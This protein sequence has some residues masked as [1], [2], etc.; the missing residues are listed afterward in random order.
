[1]DVGHAA[2][3]WLC[4]LPA[5]AHRFRVT[6][7]RLASALGAAGAELVEDS[8][9][10]EVGS[11]GALRGDAALAVVSLGSPGW[12]RGTLAARIAKRARSSV[13]V[14]I[15]AA[16]AGRKLH[17]LGYPLSEM[18]TWDL[19]HVFRVPGGINGELFARS[20]VEHLPQCALVFGY[21]EA[22]GESLVEAA[23]RDAGTAIGSRLKANRLFARGGLTLAFTDH[24]LVRVSVGPGFSQIE[25]Q[26]AALEALRSEGVPDT[27]AKRVPWQGAQGKSNLADWAVEPLLPGSSA[28]APLSRNLMMECLDFL[29]ALH[30]VK[31]SGR[32]DTSLTAAAAVVA[33][34][35]GPAEAAIVHATGRA[36]DDALSDVPRGFG[37]GDY[38][39][40]NLLV[41]DDR[42]VGVV[43]WDSAGPDRLALLDAIHLAFTSGHRPTDTD[44]GPKLV[45]ELI[46]WARAGGDDLTNEY[47]REVGLERDPEL[48]ELLVVAYWLD[49]AA[50]QLRTHAERWE[51]GDWVR[52][53]IESVARALG[54]KTS[55]RGSPLLRLGSS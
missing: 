20:P 19:G 7:A 42:L 8:P 11:P 16:Q 10:V 29:T 43:D 46:P 47:C 34:V 2:Q 40:G 22:L 33:R 48:L 49:R 12:V 50:S 27:V 17:R 6:D 5:A 32:W 39:M 51:D 41:V 13:R 21:R 14:R 36:L 24:G 23:V 15:Q 38:S 25:A 26:G 28:R 37:H 44:W 55:R 30:S 45:S 54:A 3:S 18:T 4:V 52:L 53:N 1:M 31:G 35:C 9:D